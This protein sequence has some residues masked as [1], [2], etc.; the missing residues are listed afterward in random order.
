MDV[1]LVVAAIN[2]EALAVVFVLTHFPFPALDFVYEL[3]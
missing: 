2:L 3:Y 1:T